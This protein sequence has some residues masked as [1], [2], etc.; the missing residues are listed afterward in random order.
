MR[1]W[2]AALKRRRVLGFCCCLFSLWVLDSETLQRLGLPSFLGRSD[3]V[4]DLCELFGGHCICSHMYWRNQV[5]LESCPVPL[6]PL[7]CSLDS[8]GNAIFC[9]CTQA[10]WSPILCKFPSCF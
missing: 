4:V 1:V 5:T 9:E 2:P 3:C 7:S 6:S 10:C 8:L